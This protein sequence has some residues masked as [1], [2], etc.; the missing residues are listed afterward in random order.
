[1]TDL[2]RL[3]AKVQPVPWSGCWLW[4]GYIDQLDYGQFAFGG[5]V[6]KAHRVSYELHRGPIPLGLEID[7]LCR[8]RCCV[9]P[10][11]LEA[12]TR[13]E[14]IR[15]GT[16]PDLLRV[17]RRA[18]AATVTHCPQGHPYDEANTK[19][20]SQYKRACRACQSAYQ[21]RHYLKHKGVSP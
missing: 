7:H 10:D 6:K 15:R 2:D 1:M 12:V 20:I 14:N 8:V 16:G 17:S 19:W 4:T 9:N 13:S 3:M 11:H 21:R 5:K 18:R